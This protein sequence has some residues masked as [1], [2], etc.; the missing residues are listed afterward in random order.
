MGS[1]YFSQHDH[2]KAVAFYET[3]IRLQPR[4][5]QPYVNISFAYNALGL[6]DQAEQSLR[7]ACE[8]E[9]KSPEANLN[10]GLLL[11]ELGQFER[12][13]IASAKSCRAGPQIRRGSL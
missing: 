12:G 13:R 5:I 9:P 10:L 3:A 11:G 1:F 6:N 8:L 7:R 2:R 4:A